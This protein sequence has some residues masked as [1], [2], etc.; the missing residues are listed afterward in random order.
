MDLGCNNCTSTVSSFFIN[1]GRVVN[2]VCKKGS[3]N[4]KSSNINNSPFISGNKHFLT[5][6][7]KSYVTIC[8]PYSSTYGTLC[9]LYNPLKYIIMADKR[10]ILG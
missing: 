5:L 8:F 10:L 9:E 6:G 1:V 3:K 4:L 7:I 2:P